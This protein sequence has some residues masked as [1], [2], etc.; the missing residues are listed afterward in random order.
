ME[1]TQKLFAQQ[2]ASADTL[3]ADDLES[4]EG[5]I[6]IEYGSGNLQGGVDV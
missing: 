3:T 4:M 1:T 6:K 2:N 5:I